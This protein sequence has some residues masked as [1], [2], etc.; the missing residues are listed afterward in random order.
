MI[1]LIA[2][3]RGPG[4]PPRDGCGWSEFFDQGLKYS[5]EREGEQRPH[6]GRNEGYARARFI[7]MLVMGVMG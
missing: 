6:A 3:P 4:S 1:S 7:W 5:L 2:R